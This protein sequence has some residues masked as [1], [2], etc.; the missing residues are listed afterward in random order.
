LFSCHKHAITGPE[1]QNLPRRHGDTEARRKIGRSERQNLTTD[2]TDLHGSTRFIAEEIGES[3]SKSSPL[4][5][6]IFSV[7]SV[8]GLVFPA[9]KKRPF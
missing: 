9:Y 8:V 2:N 1:N 5:F 7:S 4:I 6:P 3:E